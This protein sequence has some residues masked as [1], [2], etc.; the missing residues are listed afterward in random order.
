MQASV[1]VRHGHREVEPGADGGGGHGRG[2]PLGGGFR[3]RS[4]RVGVRQGV[5]Q[6]GAGVGVGEDRVERVGPA[7]LRLDRR[8]EPPG[9]VPEFPA[10][11]VEGVVEHGK[12]GAGQ[13]LVGGEQGVGR[14]EGG[15]LGG[16]GRPVLDPRIR[17][18]RSAQ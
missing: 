11:P 1:A 13:V 3:E 18:A 10:V 7:G 2:E 8:R 14:A 4:P 5:E 9:G 12:Q 6:P 16:G 15:R 17:A